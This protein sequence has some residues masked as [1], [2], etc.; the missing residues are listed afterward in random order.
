ML[1]SDSPERRALIKGLSMIEDDKLAK[2][3]DQLNRYKRKA[4][5]RRNAIKDLQKS[6]QMWKEIAQKYMA[7]HS[8]SNARYNE[9]RK[10]AWHIAK[11]RAIEAGIVTEADCKHI[12]GVMKIRGWYDARVTEYKLQNGIIKD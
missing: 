9:E 2:L 6:A 7:L 1:T 12:S 11:S 4:H 10:I 5:N 8:E 3:T